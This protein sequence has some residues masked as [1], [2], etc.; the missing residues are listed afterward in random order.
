MARRGTGSK[1]RPMSESA[2]T[3]RDGGVLLDPEPPTGRGTAAPRGGQDRAAHADPRP[4][5]LV[6]Q[7][8]L[9]WARE[10]GRAQA[11]CAAVEVFQAALARILP[12]PSLHNGLGAA[13]V[14]RAR[15]EPAAAAVATLTEALC[16]FQ[17]AADLVGRQ[18]TVRAA[19]LRYD[20]NRAMVLWMVG[21]R[22]AESGNL[23]EAIRILRAAADELPASSV[24]WSYVQDNLGNAL[25]ALG[26][27]KEAITAYQAALTARTEEADRARVLNNLATAYIAQGRYPE[28]DRTLQAALELTR[29]ARTPLDW[30]RAQHNRGSALLLRALADPRQPCAG[31]CF[32]D[33]IAALE[34]ARQERTRERLPADWAVTTANLAGA[35][36]GLGVSLSTQ[37]PSADP[38]AGVTHLRHALTLY[39]DALPELSLGDRRSIERNIALAEEILR[40]VSG[41]QD[42]LDDLPWPTE[43]YTQA[44]RTRKETIIDYLTRV[45][46]PLIQAGAVDLRTLRARDPS[47]AKAVDNF[48][49]KTDPVTGERRRLPPHLHL[50]TQKEVNDRLA[51]RFSDPAERPARLDWVLRARKR[52]SGRK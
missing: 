18:D 38:R 20:I 40:Q 5:H 17:T 19:K 50:P 52:R 29:R 11:A 43:T 1:V 25:M 51:A 42:P 37:E 2:I 9:A 34:L 15:F 24:H 39:H 41:P 27:T 8:L 3:V 14:E 22:T 44:H 46:L 48:V 28:G 33:A 4:Y 49:R 21:E 45:W 10:T 47:A 30:A 16:A 12:E 32:L 13:L 6:G 31:S 36:V 35:H 23:G 26:R 7:A